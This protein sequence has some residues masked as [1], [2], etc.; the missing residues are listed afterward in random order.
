MKI[1]L[2]GVLGIVAVGVLLLYVAQ[3]I[4]DEHERETISG[5]PPDPNP[6]GGP[7]IIPGSQ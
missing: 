3:Q 1:T 2:L 5:C 4:H 7:P 6:P